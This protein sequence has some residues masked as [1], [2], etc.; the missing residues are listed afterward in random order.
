MIAVLHWKDILSVRVDKIYT[1]EILCPMKHK[2]LELFKIFILNGKKSHTISYFVHGG[3]QQIVGR[4]TSERMILEDLI[5]CMG[6]GYISIQYPIM[7]GVGSN[8]FSDQFEKYH[9]KNMSAYQYL[10]K[11]KED[12]RT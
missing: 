8:D 10:N 5:N 6:E 11:I 7:W 3:E 4:K 9:I 2:D 1:G 12:G